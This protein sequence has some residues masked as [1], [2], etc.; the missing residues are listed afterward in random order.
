MTEITEIETR[1]LQRLTATLRTA[2]TAGDIATVRE[3][4]DEIDLLAHHTE[5]AFVRQMCQPYMLPN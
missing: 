1:R 2:M 3:T 5:S 4:F